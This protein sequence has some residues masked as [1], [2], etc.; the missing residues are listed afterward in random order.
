M[1][2]SA[3]DDWMSRG[4]GI[5]HRSLGGTIMLMASIL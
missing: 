5:A 1:L 4:P 2:S 3:G